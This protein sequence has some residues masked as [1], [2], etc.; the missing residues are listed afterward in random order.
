MPAVYDQRILVGAMDAGA[1]VTEFDWDG[2]N[3]EKN[4]LR[5]RVTQS[6]CEQVFFNRPLVTTEDGA[7]VTV[8]GLAEAPGWE[9]AVRVVR[10]DA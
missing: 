5:H 3:S 10:E 2:G 9:G 6:E 1:D 8:V 7:V 4:W